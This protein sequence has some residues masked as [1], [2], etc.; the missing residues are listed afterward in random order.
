MLISSFIANYLK[1]ILRS[2]FGSIRLGG[3]TL[4]ILIFWAP[5]LFSMA[6]GGIGVA[7]LIASKE[8]LV[9][10]NKGMIYLV[11]G[12]GLIDFFSRQV[13]VPLFAYMVTPIAHWK[14]SLFYQIIT[15]MNVIN[16][17]VLSFVMGFWIVNFDI[18]Y[19][20]IA[21]NWL[22]LLFTCFICVRCILNMLQIHQRKSYRVI[23]F[24]LFTVIL[25]ALIEWKFRIL[26]ITSATLFDTVLQGAFW[27][28]VLL[29]IAASILLFVST[30]RTSGDLYVDNLPMV[31][32][33]KTKISQILVSQNC[34]FEIFYHEWKLLIRNHRT[35][36][37]P[38]L[39]IMFM[40]WG[41]SY[42]FASPI[43]DGLNVQNILGFGELL[44]LMLAVS[45][46]PLFYTIQVFSNRSVF[47]E[48]ISVRPFSE[49]MMVRKFLFI[50]Q[51]GILFISII[52]MLLGILVVRIGNVSSDI[53]VWIGCMF[54]Y[55]L[56]VVNYVYMFVGILTAV[57][58]ELNANVFS[59][60]KFHR[61]DMFT[62]SLFLTATWFPAGLLLWLIPDKIWAFVTIGVAGTMGLLCH[63]KWVGFL[64][65]FLRQRRYVM[66]ERFRVN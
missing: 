39:A 27:P 63:F 60:K 62:A 9:Y 43:R 47:Y 32:S 25:L 24:L 41:L 7:H 61:R 16:L 20:I 28:L 50:S 10:I 14:I 54:I 35:K 1:S 23:L 64:A 29:T 66:F 37:S 65:A 26:S 42:V 22:L 48:G 59:I 5:L 56:G 49:T 38:L 52:A 53:I 44:E 18:Q 13:Y 33:R 36:F 2:P 11:I 57:R 31:R 17:L 12:W 55:G 21:W 19:D 15:F 58:M 45:G 4:F 3:K 8:L 40:P 6:A 46:I 30:K 51:S 34:L